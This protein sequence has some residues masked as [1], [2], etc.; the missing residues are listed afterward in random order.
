[1]PRDERR[2]YDMRRLVRLIVDEESVFEIGRGWGKS[3]ITGLAR[4]AGHPIG[5]IANDP[6]VYGGGLTAAASEKMARFADI[7][8]TFHLPVVHVVDQ[9]GFVIGTA[10]ERAGTIRYG[11]RALAAVFQVTT[12]WVALFVRRAYG[13]AGAAHGNTGGLNLR[14]AWPSADW[15]SLPLAGGIEAAY[16]RVLDGAA[17]RDAKLAEIRAELDAVR[18]PL[19]TAEAFGIEHLIDPRDSRPVLCDWVE[20]AYA[21]NAV[22]PGR[23]AHGFRP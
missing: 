13:V 3:V 2:A 7:C 16:R 11:A 6:Q 20:T 1:V 22:S 15:G 8:D 5:V 18:S 17:D 12:P 19:R 9:P 10:A 21:L 14:Y 23:K 4:L